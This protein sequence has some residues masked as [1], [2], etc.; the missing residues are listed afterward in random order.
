MALLVD[1]VEYGEPSVVQAL[2][3]TGYDPNLHDERKNS[4]YTTAL[5][6]AFSK[7]FS[8]IIQILVQAGASLNILDSLLRAI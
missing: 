5:H 3:Q 2:L 7:G 8:E 4:C 6:R 1:V